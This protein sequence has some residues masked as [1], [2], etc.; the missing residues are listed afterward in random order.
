MAK[1]KEKAASAPEAEEV[2]SRVYEAGYQIAPSVKE[3]EVEQV[4][5]GLRS[6][7]EKADGSLIA[8]GAPATVRLAYGLPGKEGSKR[9]LF[10]RAYFG[11][12]K[13]ESSTDGA[14]A[15][16]DA[17]KKDSSV[18]RSVVFRTVRED[19]RAKFKAP[20]LRE[21]KRTDAIKTAPRKTE[22][23]AAPVSEVDLD[24]ALETLTAE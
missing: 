3:E 10:D 17:L 19:T 18:L 20:T 5:S 21:V 8:E 15:L 1:A 9:V 4:V 16:A 7:V 11:W 12:L 6:V 24:K 22:E 14:H 13:F 23:S 2:V